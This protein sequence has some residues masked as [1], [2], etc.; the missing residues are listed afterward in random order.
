MTTMSELPSPKKSSS[1]PTGAVGLV[2]SII[3]CVEIAVSPPGL[4]SILL[5]SVLGFTGLVVSIVGIARGSGRAAGVFG[6]VVFILGCL[7]TFTTVL[8]IV[9]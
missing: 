1:I 2:L 6:I 4:S 9:A 3:F 5:A 7:M 8:D